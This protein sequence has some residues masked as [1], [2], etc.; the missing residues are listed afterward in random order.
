M[1]GFFM[2]KYLLCVALF[3]QGPS[4]SARPFDA[5][6]EDIKQ[7]ME[8][9]Q[10][11]FDAI[12]QYMDERFASH[13]DLKQSD[14]KVDKKKLIDISLESTH[15]VV[16]L[17]LGELNSQE[18]NI[19]ADGKSLNGEVPLAHGSAKFYVQSGRLFT[20][21]REI[22]EERK[23]KSDDKSDDQKAAAK[24]H[25]IGASASTN[26]ESLPCEVDSLENT[27]V[28]YKDGVLE[29]RLPKVP[30]KKGTKLHVTT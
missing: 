6:F 23:E 12:E 3:S 18:V 2:K 14:I 24:V 29:L 16:K 1:K 4:I 17:H 22:K 8:T 9:F 28:I 13:K 30:D 10:K 27:Q 5:I 19:E 20:F 25:Y 21:K 7:T 15:V 11:R 26:V